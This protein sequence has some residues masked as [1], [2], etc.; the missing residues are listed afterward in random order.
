[1]GIIVDETERASAQE[2]T[3]RASAHYLPNLPNKGDTTYGLAD[4]YRSVVPAR[5]RRS[6]SGLDGLAGRVV[7]VPGRWLANTRT[8]W[9]ERLSGW[10]SRSATAMMGR[11]S[12]VGKTE[13]PC[14]NFRRET[15]AAVPGADAVFSAVF[16]ANNFDPTTA[17]PLSSARRRP[18][19]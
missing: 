19:L 4:V 18:R 1:M 17:V 3:D 12:P 16:R 14:R 5:P 8:W 15:V 11:S 2:L 10:I 9:R 7:A 6:A 13:K